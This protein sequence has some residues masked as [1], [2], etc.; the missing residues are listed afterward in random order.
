MEPIINKIKDGIHMDNAILEQPEDTYRYARNFV[1]HQ[2]ANGM[3]KAATLKGTELYFTMTANEKPMAFTSIRNRYFMI[4]LNTVDNIVKFYEVFDN[5]SLDLKGV[6]ELKLLRQISNTYLNLSFDWPIRTIFGFYE[7]DDLQRIYWTDYNN[8]P[9]VVNVQTM[10]DGT[11]TKF[12]KYLSFTPILENIYGQFLFD[13]INAG[14]NL[15]NGNYFIAWQYYTKDGYYSDWSPL[16]TPISIAPSTPTTL[17]GYQE[18]EGAAPALNSSK[19]IQFRIR[20]IDTDYDSIR[21]AAFYSNDYNSSGPGII[22]YDGDIN[23]SEMT[24]YLRGSENLGTLTIDE[25]IEHTIV[26]EKCK[27][28]APVKLY[29]VAACLKERDELEFMPS[30]KNNFLPVRV[31]VLYNEL[32]ADTTGY[33]E[34]P[35]TSGPKILFGVPKCESIYSGTKGYAGIWYKAIEV[36]VVTPIGGVAATIQQGEYYRNVAAQFT[37]NSGR[38]TPVHK[39]NKYTS[40]G[41]AL[42]GTV[43]TTQTAQA[44]QARVDNIVIKGNW[45]TGTITINGLTKAITFS[46][47][48]AETVQTFVTTWGAD[49]L[50]AGVILSSHGGFAGEW[51][52]VAT[53]T[54]PGTDFSGPTLLTATSGNLS[55]TVYNTVPFLPATPQVDTITVTGTGGAADIYVNGLGPYPI[56]FVTSILNSIQGWWFR[57]KDS[58]PGITVSPPI[59]EGYPPD[60]LIFTANVLNTPFTQASISHNGPGTLSGIVT[61]I[62]PLNIGTKQIGQ[63]RI[64][65]MSNAGSGFN[66]TIG[67][68]T[69]TYTFGYNIGAGIGTFVNNNKV[70]FLNQEGVDLAQMGS[71][72]I[73]IIAHTAGTPNPA[74]SVSNISAYPFNVTINPSYVANGGASAQL[75]KITLQNSGGILRATLGAYYFDVPWESSLAATAISFRLAFINSI[76]RIYYGN[77]QMDIDPGDSSSILLTSNSPSLGFPTFTLAQAPEGDMGGSAAT[78]ALYAG[79]K[80]KVTFTLINEDGAANIS[81]NN[82]IKKITYLTSRADTV[83]AFKNANSAEFLTKNITLTNSGD[84][85]ILESTTDGLDFTT[86]VTIVHTNDNILSAVISS[87]TPNAVAR[88]QIDKITLSGVKGIADAKVSGLVRALSRTTIRQTDRSV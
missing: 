41:V 14:G 23:A 78:V 60:K 35:F 3:Y 48:I 18:Y 33:P 73:G 20:N 28:L 30:H 85:L 44:A 21:I 38:M 82:L 40:E 81:V 84:D 13:A 2:V 45:G 39:I 72:T 55:G 74:I 10:T 49:Y 6:C 63:I 61:N 37:L 88:P 47:D 69:R 75:D 65:S 56:I 8:P 11:D 53:S 67:N 27:S 19:S 62:S 83:L 87:L 32:L 58:F 70:A 25:L 51:T 31:D 5:T 59:V 71:D 1:I 9:R 43:V 57:Y 24:F 86:P 34:S 46:N 64:T 80:R 26:V 4:V 7:N 66:I 15:L 79:N 22:F 16:S 36:S 54:I 29:N 68:T 52:L 17:D 50:T 76:M 12:A 42:K 77:I